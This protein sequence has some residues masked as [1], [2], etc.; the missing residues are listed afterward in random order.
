MVWSVSPL[1][2]MQ[3]EKMPCDL[4]CTGLEGDSPCKN[5]PSAWSPIAQRVAPSRVETLTGIYLSSSKSRQCRKAF[6]QPNSEDV[7]G[8]QTLS[9]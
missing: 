2:E 9:Y 3:K 1:V 6:F 7:P 4:I 8:L 5:E